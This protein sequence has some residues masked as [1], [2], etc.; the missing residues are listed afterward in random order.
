MAAASRTP[1]TRLEG[2]S[3]AD[4]VDRIVNT[5]GTVFGLT[6]TFDTPVGD[7][8]IRGISGGEKKRVSIAEMMSMRVHL[9]CWDKYVHFDSLFFRFRSNCHA[10]QPEA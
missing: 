7:E 4:F 9:A 10:A 1:H 2:M 8:N 6:H 3:R 5:L